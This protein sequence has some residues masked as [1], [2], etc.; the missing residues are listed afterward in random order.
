MSDVILRDRLIRHWFSETSAA[1]LAYE[2]RWTSL[3]LRRVNPDLAARLEQQR[4]L[5]NRVC[6]A[7]TAHEIELQGAALCRGYFAAA[8][9]LEAAA[10]PDDAYTIGSDPVSG[11]KVAIGH[12]RASVERIIEV[13]GWQTCWVSPDEV[14]VMMANIEQFKKIASVKQ[15]FPGAEI[16]N[17]RRTNCSAEE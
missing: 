1:A 7:G 15:S 6:S 5:F 3:A 8:K 13:H 9:A 14:A 12:Q 10:E 4:E 17:L 2:R 16:S 11:F